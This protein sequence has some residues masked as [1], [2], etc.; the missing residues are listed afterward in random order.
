MTKTLLGITVASDVVLLVMFAFTS[1]F[2]EAACTSLGFSAETFLS[3]LVSVL[4]C[5]IGGFVLGEILIFYLW[6]PN[7]HSQMRG[8]LILPT[9]YL[10]F[11]FANWVLEH[12]KEFAGMQ[13]NVIQ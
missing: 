13:I 5:V 3:L 4:V 9:G 6:I 2:A 8:L 10:V 12:S 1:T 11:Y 7:I